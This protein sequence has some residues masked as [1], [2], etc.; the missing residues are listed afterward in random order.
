MR[1]IKQFSYGVVYLAIFSLIVWGVYSWIIEKAPTCFDG[2]QNQ[3]ETGI[4]CGG[5]CVSCD[6]K[7]LKSLGL[8]KVSLFSYDR[9]YSASAPIWNSNTNFGASFFE[10]EVNFHDSSKRVLH[11][12]KNTGF[13]YPGETK[14]IIESAR[15]VTGVPESA[16][17]KIDTNRIEWKKSIDF[18][19]PLYE[20]GD[21]TATIEKDQVIVSGQIIN[22]DNSVLSRVVANAFL[23][24]EFGK[25]IGA[26][27]TELKNL[28]PFQAGNFKIFIP[29]VKSLQSSI[30]KGATA[31]SVFVEVLK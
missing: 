11:T 21:V 17:I 16:E 24:D 10:Y 3:N 5:L 13:I 31:E 6:I 29:V 8:G 15:I 2:I 30:D 19:S 25:R 27:K 9:S 20:K 23:I 4:D 28:G 14:E 7:N 18:S 1:L 26:S 22:K 12:V